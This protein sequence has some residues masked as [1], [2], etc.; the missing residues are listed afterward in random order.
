MTNRPTEQRG[1]SRDRAGELADS[2]SWQER[3]QEAGPLGPIIVIAVV[4]LAGWSVVACLRTLA[5]FREEKQLENVLQELRAPLL[6]ADKLARDRDAVS[7]IAGEFS[8]WEQSR[9]PIGNSL[10]T[11]WKSRPPDLVLKRIT[12]QSQLAG[13]MREKGY[14]QPPRYRTCRIV[15]GGT[16][17]GRRPESTLWSFVTALRKTDAWGGRFDD[18]KSPGLAAK[19]VPPDAL[20]EYDFVIEGTTP[21]RRVDLPSP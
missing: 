21:M 11:T 3:L 7:I 6:D 16:I 14:A 5:A 12:L 8:G 9:I 15:M 19:R 1:K 17:S 4:V 2:R 10:F 18:L 13:G 20:P